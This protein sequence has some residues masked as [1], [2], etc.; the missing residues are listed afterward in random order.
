MFFKIINIYLSSYT[1]YEYKDTLIILSKQELVSPNKPFFT[2]DGISRFD[3]K[4]G[5]KLGKSGFFK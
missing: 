4:Q 5:S 2:V 1:W 3:Y